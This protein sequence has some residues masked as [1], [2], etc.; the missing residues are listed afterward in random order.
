[1]NTNRISIYAILS[2]LAFFSLFNSVPA[3]AAPQFYGVESVP[4][5]WIDATTGVRQRTEAAIP[6]GFDF[7][8]YG[9]PY[10]SLGISMQGAL[11]MGRDWPSSFSNPYP[12]P[13]PP[14]I[15]NT[16]LPDP[17]EPNNVIAPFWDAWLLTFRL[18][19]LGEGAVY[20]LLEGS[21]PNRRFTV[22]WIDV[23]YPVNLCPGVNCDPFGTGS[24]QVT[25]YEGSNDI[26]FRYLDVDF[27]SASGDPATYYTV[28]VE[29]SDGTQ[30]TLYYYNDNV[31]TG[32]RVT[33]QTALRFFVSNSGPINQPPI[34][35]AGNNQSVNE[36][37]TV[38]LAG[39]GTDP[40]GTISS[41][42]WTQIAG[43]NVSLANANSATASFVAPQV[44]ADIVL[45]FRLTVTD[46]QG[47]TANDTVNVTVRNIANNPPIAKAGAD[48]TVKQKTTV[49]LNGSG[50]SD[51]DGSIVSYRWR[52][53][54]GK[55]VT[56]K[57]ATSAVATFTTPSTNTTIP[58][59][60]ELTVTDNNGATASDQ[61]V[62]VV[63][64]R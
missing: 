47:A 11:V 10:S 17:T 8:F 63:T 23:T 35:N 56:L 43:P 13:D 42:A 54:A 5:Q 52:Q 27:A 15:Y 51:S 24:F 21:T 48:Q 14:I 58:L 30:G 37:A 41:Y 49:T 32:T 59:T 31:P 45:S 18:S 36:G 22:S 34:A 40:D 4:F 26:V 39:S 33:N 16:S 57:N 64:R 55:S 7:N 28:G 44:T 12:A 20:T 62:V 38:V 19:S 3:A 25:L 9:V 53:V 1:M 2:V 61:V 46:N 50:S 60:F 29:N 6:I